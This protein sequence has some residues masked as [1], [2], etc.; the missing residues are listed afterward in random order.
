MKLELFKEKS[1]QSS[2]EMILLLGGIIVIVLIISSYILNISNS[3]ENSLKRLLE[4]QRNNILN[5]L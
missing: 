5:K 1:G 4:T 2:A 3:I